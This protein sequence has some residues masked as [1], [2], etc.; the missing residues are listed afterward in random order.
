MTPEIS[1]EF[2]PPNTPVGVE[3]LVTTR[4]T[5]NAL[6]PSFFS[7]TYGAGGAT[8]EKTFSVVRDMAGEGLD[9]APHM[10]CIGS[11][12]ASIAELLERYRSLGVRRIVALRGDLPSGVGPSHGGDFRY[13]SDLV[14]FIR[15]QTGEH[16]QI[17]VAAYPEK[18]PQASSYQADLDAF[19]AKVNA[20]ADTA[21][22]QYFYS[23]DAYFRFRDDCVA[24]GVNIPLIPGIMPIMNASQLIRF[25][26]AC[27]AEIPRWIRIR[28]ADYGDDLVSIRQFGHEV[29]T[30]LCEQLLEGGAPGLHVYTLNQS[31][32]TVLLCQA[33]GMPR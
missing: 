23:A 17:E 11:T 8:Q 6:K 26:E 9:V 24:R 5:L 7:V 21:I 33:L 15:E 28:L 2:F 13:A 12:S 25:S 10:S 4:A 18:H 30:R 3:K 31:E 14:R 20:G 19:Q 22:S 32:P 16:F 29:V 27:G 1:F